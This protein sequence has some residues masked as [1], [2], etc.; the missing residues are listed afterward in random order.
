MKNFKFKNLFISFLFLFCIGGVC[1]GSAYAQTGNLRSSD[2]LF[3]F[4]AT[5]DSDSVLI[6]VPADFVLVFRDTVKFERLFMLQNISKPP[7]PGAGFTSVYSKSGVLF[8]LS[9]SGT[10][11]DLT[12]GA[13]S[14]DVITVNG[15]SVSDAD[16]DNSTP[17]APAAAQNVTWQTSGAGPADISAYFTA[18][19]IEDLISAR[20]LGGTQTNITVTHDDANNEWDFVVSAGGSGDSVAVEEGGVSVDTKIDSLDFGAGFDVVVLNGDVDVTLDF[21]E[22][23]GHDNFTDFV[24]NEHINHTSITLTAGTNLNGGGTIAESRTFNL[25]DPIVLNK[26]DTDSIGVETVNANFVVLARAAGDILLQD[27][28]TVTGLFTVSG[29]FDIGTNNFVYNTG[30][31]STTD[32]EILDDGVIANTELS[33][34]VQ[35]TI[36]LRVASGTGDPEDINI[37]AGLTLVASASGDFIIIEDA[38]D[39]NLKRVD[40]GD[41][42]GG[43]ITYDAIS[44]AAGNGS[45][46]MG[47]TEQIWVSSQTD[48][49]VSMFTLDINQVD[50]A[51]ATD[52]LVAWEIAATS[53]SGDTGDTFRLL[54]LQY[55]EGTANTIL[56]AAILIDN[57]ET[58]ASTMTDAIIITS[59]G[60]SGGVVDAIDVS[61]ANITNAINIGA[62]PIVFSTGSLSAL[63]LEIL[64]DGTVSYSEMTFSNNI[65]A[66]DIGTD[67]IALTELDD[68]ANSPVAGDFLIVETGAISVSYRSDQ[69]VADSL[70]ANIDHDNLLNFVSGEHILHSGVTLT[71][72]DGL[73][74]G[75]TIASNRTFTVNAHPDSAL[76]ISG[77][78]LAVRIDGSSILNTGNQLVVGTVTNAMVPNNITID[79]STLATTITVTD[80][81]ATVETNA[82]LFT[83]AGDLDGGTI[84]A[85]SDGD[86][87]YN[88]GTGNFGIGTAIANARLTVKA[89][90]SGSDTLL[91]IYGDL[92]TD[93]FTQAD[94]LGLVVLQTGNVGIGT[95]DIDHTFE[96]SGDVQITRIAT[97]T[98]QHALEIVASANGIGDYKA[99]DIVYS[100]GDLSAG[101]DEAIVLVNIDRFLS[102]GGDISAFEVLST[103]GGATVYGLK[104][105]AEINPIIQLS[106]NFVNADTVVDNNSNVTA[107]VSEG[108][109]GAIAVFTADNDSL[110]IGSTAKFEEIEMIYSI[111]ASGAGI[112]PK[113]E[114]STGNHAWTVFTPIDGTNGAQNNGGVAWL[115]SDIGAW[116][117]GTGNY[118]QILVTRQRNSLS[119]TP[120]LDSLRIAATTLYTWD[121]NGNLTINSMILEGST[122]DANEHTINT[123]D[124][125]A[126]RTFNFPNDQLVAGDVLVASDA[127]DLEYLNLANNQLLFGDGAGIPTAAVLSGHATNALGVVTIIDFALTTSADG[128][129]NNIT[130][131]GNIDVDSLNADGAAL[132]IADG[133]V[134]VA[135]NSSDWDISATGVVTGVAKSPA[136][137][138]LENVSFE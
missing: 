70:E 112:D 52:D 20:L 114:F 92:D 42:L 18:E 126:D 87:T 125:T 8:S 73:S 77:D 93:N 98:D 12:A 71:A 79:L 5:S 29:N 102:T 53:E 68:D 109:A 1:V 90:T 6:K 86:L 55:E 113:F 91:A 54:K 119:T 110:M 34:M 84:G 85:E 39:G 122:N 88:P 50:D 11:S 106:G 138:L 62:N 116:A 75:G 35:N 49:D 60:V 135:I 115:D 67:A 21:T 40:A 27:S 46:G 72:G 44:D 117:I 83:D 82:L 37:S 32:L 47:A 9:S 132:L 23:A 65:V 33:N 78:S 57:A 123:I 134:T 7:N 61:A 131:V 28:T 137:I 111:F 76:G 3:Y 81:E 56:D 51:D 95:F 89:G 64:D 99:V 103:E 4:V 120:V 104:I 66:G 58:T 96:V 108:G 45:L 36:K 130:N 101:E 41:F 94:S 31:L 22:V 105:G 15:S 107:A 136:T 97:A 63:D 13:T 30:S 133:Q 25:D 2:S 14:G 19:Q 80:N 38:T 26:V 129:D 100:S 128:G 118:F 124:L 127:S 24:A 48:G 10:E 121:N 16:F 69:E 17:S 74:G 59:S 43:G